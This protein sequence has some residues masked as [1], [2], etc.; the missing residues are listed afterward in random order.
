MNVKNEKQK[1]IC[2]AYK[3]GLTIAQIAKAF[4]HESSVIRTYLDKYFEEIYEEKF[5]PCLKVKEEEMKRLYEKYQEVYVQ[6]LFSREQICEILGCNVNKLEAMLRRYGLKN[7]WLKTYH[8]QK[9]LCNV[10]NEFYKSVKEFAQKNNYKSV[11]AVA[12]RAINEFMLQEELKK[13][14]EK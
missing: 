11:R 9:T 6:G 3:N 10:S 14:K 2:M 5:L 8:N 13:D 12:T 1:I 4:N 7:Q